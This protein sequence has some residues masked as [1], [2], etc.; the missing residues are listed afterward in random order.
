[1]PRIRHKR[2]ESISFR[3]LAQMEHSDNA[4]SKGGRVMKN[5]FKIGQRVRVSEISET[6][7]NG[8]AKPTMEELKIL[9]G[10]CLTELTCT[11]WM[12]WGRSRPIKQ[13]P[14]G[15][16]RKI[17]ISKCLMYD[18]LSD[19]CN[20]LLQVRIFS[21]RWSFY[22]PKVSTSALCRASDWW[23]SCKVFSPG[24]CYLEES[25]WQGH[26]LQLICGICQRNTLLDVD[27]GKTSSI[28]KSIQRIVLTF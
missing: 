13:S 23:S 27:G 6:Q 25:G 19:E 24:S 17:T 9:W 4:W 3:R 22:L 5:T 15:S 26:T 20:W 16:W 28:T 2:E 10:I 12:S 7:V 14:F 11:W 21:Q 1:M 8:G 18:W